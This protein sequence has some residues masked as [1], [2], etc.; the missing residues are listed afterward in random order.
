MVKAPQYPMF[1][2]RLYIA[3]PWVWRIL[4]KQFLVIAQKP[5]ATAGGGVESESGK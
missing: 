3:F 4:G 1:F 2:V 5:A